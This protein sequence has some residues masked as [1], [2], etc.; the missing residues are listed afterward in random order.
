MLTYNDVLT[1]DLSKLTTAADKW[2]SM[3][4]EFKKVDDRYEEAVQK[5]TNGP[6]WSGAS[7]SAA[8]VRSAMTRG[9][10]SG[11]QTEA[12]AIASLLRQA[13]A[14]FVT[15]KK[16][17]ESARDDAIAAGM[18]VSAQ[19]DV[20]YDYDTL[21]AGEKNALR[22]D[23][24]Y[25]TSV[26]KSEE[27][28]AKLIKDRVKAVQEFD[29]EI[30]KALMAAAEGTTGGNGFNRDAMGTLE[31]P[32]SGTQMNLNAWKMRGDETLN[33][34]LLRVQGQLATRITGSE[35]FGNLLKSYLSGS[36]TLIGF[37]TA[38]GVS[39]GTG[40]SLAKHFKDPT[41]ILN[42][43]GT[44]KARLLQQGGT[45]LLSAGGLLNRLPSGAINAIAGSD[46]AA[47]L[48]GYM[49]NGTFFMPAA[50]EANLLTVAKNGGLA[51]AAKAAGAMR[52]LGVVGSAGATVW[53][54]ANLATYDSEKI[55]K[56][57]A[58]F[59]SD[60]TGTAF[61]GSLTMAMVAPTPVT[62]GLAVGTGIAYG[63]A[64][65]WD[66]H[67]A[68]GKGIGKATEWAGDAAGEVGSKI[69]SGAKSVG[70]FLNPFD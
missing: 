7:A 65:I 4:G 46:E 41:R 59:A 27:S 29:Q 14:E 47:M 22:H 17:V 63:G 28:W 51:N 37:A 19:G 16:K 35:Q 3:A 40:I 12:K 32:G 52:G 50:S 49:K 15:L 67:E 25:L 26:R 34:Y 36:T 48:G 23:P 70:K 61:N 5:V 53:G 38:A 58:K 30:K 55:S 57:P 6:A 10:Y 43:P 1:T 56:D 18:K 66:N 13:H 64:L 8:S 33:D 39:L 20:S 69:S 54:V 11:A 31:D 9:E 42:A 68:I 60:L 2:Q 45:R 24:D 62:V 44:F 21:T